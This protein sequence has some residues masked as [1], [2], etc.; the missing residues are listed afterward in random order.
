MFW[1]CIDI[2]KIIEFENKWDHLE[3]AKPYRN[4]RLFCF[5]PYRSQKPLDIYSNRFGF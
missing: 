3:I 4:V 1:G 5:Y 2:L